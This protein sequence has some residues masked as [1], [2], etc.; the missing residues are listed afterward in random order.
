MSYL[1]SDQNIKII[2]I[3]G[4]TSS[5]KSDLALKLAH[6][7]DAEIFSLDSLSI[8]KEIDIASAKPSKDDLKAIKHY[9]INE[10]EISQTNNAAVFR[11]LLELALKTTLKK[12]LLIVGGSSFY[13]KSII[14]GLSPMPVISSEKKLEIKEQI[15]SLKDPYVFLKLI[16]FVY[17]NSIKPTDTY[18]LHKALE[19]FFV[20][21]IP[22]SQYF[23]LYKKNAFACPIKLYALTID[24]QTLRERIKHRT[25]VMIHKGIVEETRLLLQKYAPSC[26]PFKAIGPKECM[27]YLE[28]KINQKELEELIFVHTCQLAKRQNTFNKTQFQEVFYG[29]AKEIF[30]SISSVC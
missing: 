10:L 9:G 7:L 12:T 21:Q 1:K 26:Q 13:L 2:A 5:G 29:S 15:L 17:A 18:R 24:R 3:I 16:D 28:N 22:P 30:T 14:E 20:T 6:I 27:A 4:A 8:Y 11:N 25:K 19:I 23:K